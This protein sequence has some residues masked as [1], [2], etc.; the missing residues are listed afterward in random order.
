MKVS[1]FLRRY[2]ISGQLP[3]DEG[4]EMLTFYAGWLIGAS[5]KGT[6]TTMDQARKD[7]IKIA[8]FIESRAT[9]HKSQITSHEE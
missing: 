3:D 7:A 2:Q 5:Y 6:I 9:N 4:D 1:D 8:E